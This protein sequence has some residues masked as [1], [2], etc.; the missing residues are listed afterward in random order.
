MQSLIQFL[1]RFSAFFLFLALEV[2]CF[3][4]II[5]NNDHQRS[6]FLNSSN[7]ISAKA[8][9]WYDRAVEY[10]QLQ[11]F[12]DS[13]AREN[14]RLKSELY[15]NRAY[16]ELQKNVQVDSLLNQRFETISAQVINNSVTSR[17]NE[18][19]IDRGRDDGILPGMGVIGERGIVGI[20]RHASGSFSSVL[21]VLHS[22]AKVSASISRTNYFGS[23]EWKG[24]DPT[25]LSLEA[26]PKHAD[27]RVG[28]TVQTSGFSHIFPAGVMIGI[29]D[30]FAIQGGKQFLFY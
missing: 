15:N 28:D 30:T 22:S 2:I 21:S 29:V 14:A 11:E 6:I 9:D 25:T 17:N 19:T 16:Q 27:V 23:L 24:F 12:A 8:N 1:I 7:I 5:R 3:W 20:V 10:S 4:L 13:L 26:V 18:I